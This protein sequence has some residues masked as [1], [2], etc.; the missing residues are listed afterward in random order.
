MDKKRTF[1]LAILSLEIAVIALIGG[2]AVRKFLVVSEEVAPSVA[3][4]PEIARAPI[5]LEPPP[6]PPPIVFPEP[7]SP[8]LEPVIASDDYRDVAVIINRNSVASMEIGEY[9]ASVR[10]IPPQNL[11]EINATTTEEI[12]DA[13]F[14]SIRTQIENYLTANNL[15]DT[16]NYLVTTKG[17]PLK[18]NRYSA[19]AGWDNPQN[20]SASVESELSLILGRYADR[21]G[22]NGRVTNPYYLQNG[23]FTRKQYDV[24]LVTRLDAYT[25]EE[26]ERMIDR[27]TPPIPL[28]SSAK[29]VFDQDPA[30]QLHLNG[31]MATA[32]AKLKEK[33]FNT[34]LDT[35]AGFVT[36]QSDVVGYVSWG[37]N[38]HT[39]KV[40]ENYT[41]LYE[42]THAKPGNAWH[43]GAIAETYVSTSGRTFNRPVEYGQS[44]IADLIAEGITGAK[45]YVYEPFASAMTEVQI[46]FILYT[47]GYNLAESFY[48]SSPFLSW[49]DVVIGDPKA[50]L[51]INN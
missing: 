29:F 45:G 19:E 43:R 25:V 49:M 7:V 3:S 33:S 10:E 37:S 50:T 27:A 35:A 15:K 40:G 24:Y 11:I 32:A 13:E 1:Q 48:G 38:D 42:A 28:S 17:M 8:P 34:L 47:G 22:G 36:G 16:I 20:A 26:V 6:K 23:H 4:E 12:N 21:I 14:Q 9:F 5:V 2:V 30:W 39:F 31:V 44:L 46:L 18:I 51:V 41:A